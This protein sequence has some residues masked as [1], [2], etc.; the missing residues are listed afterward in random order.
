MAG[1]ITVLAVGYLWLGDRSGGSGPGA[2]A[3]IVTDRAAPS[4]T[5]TAPPVMGASVASPPTTQVPVGAVGE[6]VTAP[7]DGS[8]V[9]T[10]P[11][12]TYDV[13]VEAATGVDPVEFAAAVDG[14]LSDPRSWTADGSVSFQRVAE[15]GSITVTLATPATTDQICL[16]LN[17]A[18]IFSCREGDRAV[19]N[20]TRWLEGTDDWDGPL[21]EY[22]AMVINHE[23][24]H[25][26]GHGHVGCQGPGELA[27]VMMQQTKGLEGCVG[28]GWPFP[29]R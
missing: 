2:G 19:I 28:N 16:P 8:V 13:E 6:F 11:L 27:P 3:A 9:G 15:G 14:I 22:R 21:E 23:V 24:G 18:G 17:T 25:T 20:L 7:A 4:P 5:S 29:D 10:G 12:R 26:L 1:V